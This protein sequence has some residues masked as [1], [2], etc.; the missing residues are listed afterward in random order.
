MLVR[1]HFKTILLYG[2]LLAIATF[3]LQ[4][5]EYQY[6]L[7]RYSVEL[8]IVL[9]CSLFTALG[10]W[11]GTSLSLPSSSREEFQPSAGAFAELGISEREAEVLQLLALGHSNQEMA[12]AL[13]IS[14]N[15]VKT[16]LKNLY[17]KLQATHR[18]HAVR[19]ARTLGL[20]R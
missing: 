8:Y 18:G 20:V 14:L 13:H 4:W 17:T 12:D 2:M 3:L 6:L 1:A 7:R 10:I 5:L 9:L 15:T 16:H 11:L 19:R